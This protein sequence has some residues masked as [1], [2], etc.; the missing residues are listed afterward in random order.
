MKASDTA[1]K[2]RT[3]GS[4]E[5]AEA[6]YRAGPARAVD[7]KGRSTVRHMQTAVADEDEVVLEG[8]L[9]HSAALLLKILKNIGYIQRFK[10]QPF[11]L[12][13]S[14]D[15]VDAFPDFLVDLTDTRR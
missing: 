12:T 5:W 10:H 8:R 6:I 13:K 4:P 7:G 1:M 2:D 11:E 9:E 3:L 15:E 14:S